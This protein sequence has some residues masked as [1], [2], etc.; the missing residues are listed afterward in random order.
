MHHPDSLARPA[1]IFERAQLGPRRKASD[2]SNDARWS[3][4]NI[5]PNSFRWLGELSTD[6]ETVWQLRAEFKCRC[7]S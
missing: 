1:F 3:F 6:G 7:K 5:A 4:T 2:D